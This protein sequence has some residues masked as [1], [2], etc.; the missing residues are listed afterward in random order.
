L[1][2]WASKGRDANDRMAVGSAVPDEK[3]Q[4]PSWSALICSR[5][6]VAKVAPHVEEIESSETAALACNCCLN[7]RIDGAL[8]KAIRVKFFRQSAR[9]QLVRQLRP[10]PHD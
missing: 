7:V 4:F 1:D 3:K 10:V 9:R 5:P 2:Y 6:R 8:K